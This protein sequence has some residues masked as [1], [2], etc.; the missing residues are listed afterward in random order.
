MRALGILM[1]VVGGLVA[2]FAVFLFDPSVESGFG[3]GRINNLGL[4]QDRQNYLIFGCA[5]AIVGSI[6]AVMGAR[7]NVAG[8]HPA[9]AFPANGGSSPVAADAA[10]TEDEFLAAIKREDVARMHQLLDGGG[11][12]AYGENRHG[13]SWLVSAIAHDSLESTKLLLERGASATRPDSQK[14]LP[15]EVA[16][17]GGR[18][19]LIAMVASYMKPS[20]PK[21]PLSP[22]V[23]PRP[24]PPLAKPLT[25]PDQLDRLV[26]LRESGMLTS[27]EFEKAKGRI[28]GA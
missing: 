1:L 23:V 10:D 17:R 6:L 11:I 22:Q 20:A 28:L 5:L 21:V 4:M 15:I 27:D 19:E 25:L 13:R 12:K 7:Q 18:V 16:R 3:G 26:A 8:G 14:S 2:G 24:S 9:P